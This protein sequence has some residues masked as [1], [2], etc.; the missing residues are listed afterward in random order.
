LE[1]T[2]KY[3]K[4]IIENRKKYSKKNIDINITKI[5]NIFH[6]NQ[7]SHNRFY[8]SGNLNYNTWMAPN[9][10]KTIIRPQ[11]SSHV[12]SSSGIENNSFYRYN[13]IKPDLYEFRNNTIEN[14]ASYSAL[15]HKKIYNRKKLKIKC[16]YLQSNK[17]NRNNINYIDDNN[18]TNKN[19]NKIEKNKNNIVNEKNSNKN[20]IL[21]NN[22]IKKLK[23]DIEEKE[24][25]QKQIEE[26]EKEQ[27]KLYN[28]FYDNF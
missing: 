23:V 27:N 4:K 9:K 14:V 3:I 26:I 6:T 7:N 28:K 16:D 18:D 10:K 25:I 13:K 11:K 2:K 5:N 24:K 1:N 17:E 20:K 8:H 12:F 15:G 19:G 22:I 21:K